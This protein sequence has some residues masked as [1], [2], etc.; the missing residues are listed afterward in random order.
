MMLGIVLVLAIGLLLLG[1]TVIFVVRVVQD[2]RR[3][4]WASAVAFAVAVLISV[5]LAIL[6]AG[7]VAVTLLRQSSPS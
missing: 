7:L 2:L 6:S 1:A 5:F 4:A 3:G